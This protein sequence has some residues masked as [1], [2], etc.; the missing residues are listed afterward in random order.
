MK[1]Q[2]IF[3]NVQRF[4]EPNGGPI[5]RALG[6]SSKD[7][8][9]ADYEAKLTNIATCLKEITNDEQPAL[10]GICRGGNRKDPAKT[11]AQSWDGMN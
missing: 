4:F 2:A 6:A 8:T 9:E 5:A 10:L 1:K 3:W 11:Y 7:W